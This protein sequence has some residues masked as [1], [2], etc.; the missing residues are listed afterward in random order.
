M[1]E[2]RRSIWG[3]GRRQALNL[4]AGQRTG[5]QFGGGTEDRRSIWGRGRGQALNLGAER[6]TGLGWKHL[7]KQTSTGN[8]QHGEHL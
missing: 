8:F 3:R 4:G 1:A 7:S 5:A 6:R 2:D